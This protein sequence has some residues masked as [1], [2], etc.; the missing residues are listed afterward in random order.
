MSAFA[1]LVERIVLDFKQA[2]G[3]IVI[4]IIEKRG[5]I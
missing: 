5:A 3:A 1:C 4:E 2:L